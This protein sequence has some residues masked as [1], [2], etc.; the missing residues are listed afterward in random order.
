MIYA[1]EIKRGEWK[2]GGLASENSDKLTTQYSNLLEDVD[3]HVHD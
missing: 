1:N 2:D 3:E